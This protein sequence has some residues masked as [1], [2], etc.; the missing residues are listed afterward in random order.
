MEPKQNQSFFYEF[1][2]NFSLLAFKKIIMGTDGNYVIT[3]RT[4]TLGYRMV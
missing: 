4:S 2:L 1:G 3:S